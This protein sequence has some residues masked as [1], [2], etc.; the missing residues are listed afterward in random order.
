MAVAIN[1][2]DKKRIDPRV[3]RTRKL[4]EQAFMELMNEKGFR[5][6]TIQDI[7]ER[8]TVNRATFY[9]HFEDKYDMLDSFI[10]QYFSETLLD[11]VPLAPLYT[12]ERL[13]QIIVTVMEFLAPIH[14]HCSPSSDAQQM[15]PM[16]ESAVQEELKGYLLAW[17][18]LAQTTLIPRGV[19]PQTAANV[20]SWAIF[21]TA[22]QWA[23]EG[24]KVSAGKTAGEISIVLTASCS[25]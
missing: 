9:A 12:M 11:K 20:W 3:L 19:N 4:L 24:Q 16:L 22:Y 14:K 21:G 8:A 10:R 2:E 1:K 7:T 15:T 25:A 17:F 6:M 23:Q 13:Q 18:K 5:A